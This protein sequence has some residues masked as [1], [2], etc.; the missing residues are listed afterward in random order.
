MDAK[1]TRE[2]RRRLSSEHEK[3]TKSMSRSR[4]AEDEI[5][6]EKTEDEGDLA[7]I[8]Q[9]KDILYSLHESDFTRLRFIQ[10]ALNAL[11]RGEYGECG[12][13]GEAIGEKRL[14]AVP[15]AMTCI[16]CQEAKEAERVSS[17]AQ[18]E[19]PTE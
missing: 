14:N 13:C 16:G 7:T 1:K 11:D 19:L 12:R 15:W 5:G 9:E 6:V 8:S 17:S 3:L 10:E 18:A 4:I 2:F